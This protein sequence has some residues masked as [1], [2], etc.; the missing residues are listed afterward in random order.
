MREMIE[1]TVRAGVH[2][3][4]VTVLVVTSLLQAQRRDTTT[5]SHRRYVLPAFMV[6]STISS[7]AD[8][9]RPSL[10]QSVDG[11]CLEPAAEEKQE[12]WTNA[13]E[14]CTSTEN[15]EQGKAR[16]E[17][18]I[19]SVVECMMLLRNNY[20]VVVK[21]QWRIHTELSTCVVYAS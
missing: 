3:P 19:C 1:E 5:N 10:E 15:R 12:D 6:S 20:G 21:K 9:A 8:F 13:N 7:M 11:S 18:E 4:A 2:G 14:G 16:Q 17:M